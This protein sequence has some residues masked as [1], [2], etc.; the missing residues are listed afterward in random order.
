MIFII[1]IVVGIIGIFGILWISSGSL[2]YLE[3]QPPKGSEW[4]V[5]HPENLESHLGRKLQEYARSLLKFALIWLIQAYRKISKE[6]TIKQVVKK[7][8][9]AFLYDHTPDGVR[10]PSEFWS[11]VRH[12]DAPKVEKPKRTRKPKVVIEEVVITEEITPEIISDD[13]GELPLSHN[14]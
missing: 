12:T 8:V 11:R 2:R 6:I 7:K 1:C 5:I 4:Y 13:Q 10:H 9:R 3:N 14:E